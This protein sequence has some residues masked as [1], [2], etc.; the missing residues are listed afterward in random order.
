M[1]GC[2]SISPGPEYDNI[3]LQPQLSQIIDEI[4]NAISFGICGTA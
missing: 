2:L 3:V 1:T 4:T